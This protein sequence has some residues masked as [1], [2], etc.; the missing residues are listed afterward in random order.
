M[1]DN[2]QPRSGDAAPDEAS[3]ARNFTFKRSFTFGRRPAAD[4][5]T[6]TLPVS[7]RE[8]RWELGGAAKPAGVETSPEQE[9]ATYYEALT[10]KPDPNRQFFI[11]ARRT[12][13]LTVT[14]LALAI[15]I[16]LV[17]LGIITGA[18]VQ[19]IVF[20]GVVGLIVGLM[21]KTSFPRTP[22]G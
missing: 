14:I 4:S 20:M 13:N 11:T 22:F 7:S 8:F 3:P 2:Q 12:L 21:I 17:A 6:E 15:P 16:G 19:T 18:D 5:D 9:P 10:G 1:T